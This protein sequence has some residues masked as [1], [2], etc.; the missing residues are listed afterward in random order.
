M[1]ILEILIENGADLNTL[2]NDNKTALHL[3]AY[4]NYYDLCSFLVA[5]E[6]ELNVQDV[7]G[8]TA[9]HIAVELKETLS[10]YS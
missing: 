8:K 7:S 4:Y 5:N 1:S 10:A 2:S 6:C 9:L 3:A